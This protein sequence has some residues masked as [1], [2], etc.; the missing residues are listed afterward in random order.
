ME[1]AALFQQLSHL[2][3]TMPN[4]TDDWQKTSS[5]VWLGRATALVEQ[6]GNHLD[7]AALNVASNSLG[8]IIHLQNVQSITAVVYRSLARAELDAPVH[9]KN[10]FLP[11]DEPFAAKAALS[12]VMAA[13][14]Q[15][16]LIIDPHADGTLL[17]DFVPLAPEA[18]R[19]TVVATKRGAPSLAAL[20]KS[21]TAQYGRARPLEI[22]IAAAR[23]LHDRLV[24]IDEAEVWAVGQSFNAIAERSPTYLT[25]LEEDTAAL[26]VEAY[27]H[28]ATTAP[29]L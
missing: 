12:K 2:A 11:V 13:A 1:K 27:K 14:Y 21:W 24:I 28:I 8:S 16:I 4:L 6:S 26:K 7:I 22:R 19:V 20:S 9:V 15:S 10:G 25:A 23:D 29:L 18:V 17:T 5:R 3:A